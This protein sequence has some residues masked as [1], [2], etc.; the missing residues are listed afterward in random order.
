[1][2]ETLKAAWPHG[3]LPR[4][5]QGDRAAANAAGKMG[6]ALAMRAHPK[7][8]VSAFLSMQQPSSGLCASY[9]PLNRLCGS[10]MVSS[11]HWRAESL[12]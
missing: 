2:D 3:V 12:A 6:R 4:L 1:V 11:S 5:Q 10:S 9:T 8:Q 7:S